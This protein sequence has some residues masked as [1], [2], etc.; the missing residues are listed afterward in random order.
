[1]EERGKI[2]CYSCS[3]GI[4]VCLRAETLPTHQ[5]RKFPFPQCLLLHVLFL[6]REETSRWSF[7]SLATSAHPVNCFLS[8]CDLAFAPI[9]LEP[10]PCLLTMVSTFQQGLLLHCAFSFVLCNYSGYTWL[11]IP[12]PTLGKM[13]IGK[14]SGPS[15]S[16]E[17]R[18]TLL[19]DGTVPG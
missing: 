14:A 17:P 19:Q 9:I 1:M 10:H 8:P 4:G 5:F 16:K 15:P 2:N 18:R 13:C 3:L 12:D 7:P 6:Q 11:Y